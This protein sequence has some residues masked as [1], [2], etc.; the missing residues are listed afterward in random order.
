MTDVET[1]SPAMSAGIQIGDV[2][3]EVAGE[4]VTSVVTYQRA[5]LETEAGSEITIGARRLGADGYVDVNFKVTV[6]SKE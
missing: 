3:C 1:D 2:I 5:L 4:D 6:G